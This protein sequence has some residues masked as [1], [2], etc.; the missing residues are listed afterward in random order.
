MGWPGKRV[1][2]HCRGV[3]IYWPGSVVAAGRGNLMGSVVTT[4]RTNMTLSSESFAGH[5]LPLE[6]S[7]T[8]VTRNSC[9]LV[10]HVNHHVDV[11]ISINVRQHRVHAGGFRSRCSKADRG[12]VHSCS[13][14][15]AGRQNSHSNNTVAFGLNA[16]EP[17]AGRMSMSADTSGKARTSRLEALKK[18][19][20]CDGSALQ[21]GSCRRNPR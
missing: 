4:H 15:T 5:S 9:F 18:T 1:S 3:S 17:F 16:S 13:I 21:E 2:F 7:E 8:R 11:P 6:H 14:K 12:S 19:W 20:P 10:P